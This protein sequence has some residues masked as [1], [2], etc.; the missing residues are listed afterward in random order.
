MADDK[1]LQY[2]ATWTDDQIIE[3]DGNFRDD[4][5]LMLLCCE[6]EVDIYEYRQVIA[7]VFATESGLERKRKG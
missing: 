7:D 5:N 4:G 6:R 1:M 3:W 2:S